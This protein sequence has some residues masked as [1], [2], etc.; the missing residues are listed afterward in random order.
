MICITLHL[1]NHRLKVSLSKRRGSGW[2]KVF[3]Q[4]I[5]EIT[6]VRRG[7]RISRLFRKIFELKK[8]KTILGGNLVLVGIVASTISPHVSAFSVIPQTE[9]VSLSPAAIE[10]TT[11]EGMRI[12]LDKKVIT[13]RFNAFHQGVD[14][15]GTTGDPVYPFMKGRIESVIYSRIDYGNH[16]IINHGL[17]LKSLYAH[18]SKIEVSSGEKVETNKEIGKIGSTGR[19]FGDH[20]HFEI[21]DNGNHVNPLTVLPL[22]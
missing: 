1:P 20:L 5:Q 18:L 10:L 12:P 21:I 22:K 6:S 9:T 11:N 8:I 17:G 14:F 3:S 7:S 4:K 15:D 16:I 19:A 13:Q 2:K